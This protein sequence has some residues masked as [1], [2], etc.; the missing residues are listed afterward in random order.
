MRGGGR[1][2]RPPMGSL[3]ARRGRRLLQGGR[4]AARQTPR[5]AACYTSGAHART[6]AAAL[7]ALSPFSASLIASLATSCAAGPRARGAGGLAG[8]RNRLLRRAFPCRGAARGAAHAPGR[9][10]PASAP[11][12]P[13]AHLS[14]RAGLLRQSHRLLRQRAGLLHG[15]AR[16]KAAGR[17]LRRRERAAE[18]VHPCGPRLLIGG[19]GGAR[20]VAAAGR[21]ED[22]TAHP[23]ARSAAP[24]G[25]PGAPPRPSPAP[26]FGGRW[27]RAATGTQAFSRLLRAP[28]P[29]L[30]PSLPSRAP[31]RVV[32]RLP[33]PTG[34]RGRGGVGR[35]GDGACAELGHARAA[36]QKAAGRARTAGGAPVGEAGRAARGAPQPSPAGGAG[37]GWDA[38]GAPARR[39]R[40][41]PPRADH[42]PDGQSR[43]PRAPRPPTC[44]RRR[45]TPR[46]G[47]PRTRRR[48]CR[49]RRTRGT[50]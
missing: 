42:P 27:S 6:W 11:S 31:A 50:A 37:V 1:L 39:P 30:L 25:G 22:G 40:A 5:G 46:A 48:A 44:P 35:V 9:H 14:F 15:L 18:P 13:P 2:R 8:P 45:R 24:A 49:E 16:N 7:I 34:G 26:S 41:A 10:A 36:C 21:G 43:R 47:R 38:I 19:E 29:P 17:L 12:P 28:G 32:C 23:A 33:Q 20:V 3:A 4:G